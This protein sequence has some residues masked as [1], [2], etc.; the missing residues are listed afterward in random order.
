[1]GKPKEKS[2]I[3]GESGVKKRKKLLF[4]TDPADHCLLWLQLDSPS[5]P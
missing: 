1:M 3:E 2:G 5:L 4:K